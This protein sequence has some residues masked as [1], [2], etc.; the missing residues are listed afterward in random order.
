M[1][2]RKRTFRAPWVI[3]GS[4]LLALLV[5]SGVAAQFSDP[6]AFA[7]LL[8]CSGCHIEDGS[9][10]PPTV[11][12]LRQNLDLLL[13]TAEGRA[14]L[15]QVPGITDSPVPAVEMAELMNWLIPYLYPSLTGFKPFSEEEVESGRANRLADPTSVRERLLSALTSTLNTAKTVSTGS[16]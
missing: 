16:D 7:Y 1:P 9:G 11:P 12:D 2:E 15:L 5:S 6:P 13:T 14:Y 8:H 4:A 10:D 3:G